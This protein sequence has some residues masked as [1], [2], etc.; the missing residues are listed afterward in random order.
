MFDSAMN[1]GQ[2]IQPVLPSDTVSKGGF[3]R[4]V[5]EAYLDYDPVK[6][7]TTKFLPT[8]FGIGVSAAGGAV[9]FANLAE[10]MDRF[11][12]TVRPGTGLSDR[13]IEVIESAIKENPLAC[14]AVAG[15]AVAIVGFYSLYSSLKPIT[16]ASIEAA[17]DGVRH[18]LQRAIQE[19]EVHQDQIAKYNKSLSELKALLPAEAAAYKQQSQEQYN[20]CMAI[21]RDEANFMAGKLKGFVDAIMSSRLNNPGDAPREYHERDFYRVGVELTSFVRNLDRDQGYLMLSQVRL[22]KAVKPVLS[23]KEYDE[24]NR[25]LWSFPERPCLYVEQGPLAREYAETLKYSASEKKQLGVLRARIN[26]VLIQ[27]PNLKPDAADNIPKP[28]FEEFL[29]N[30]PF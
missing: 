14:G 18:E 22:L 26:Q 4:Y 21:Y 25:I 19:T 20:K 9:A 7:T 10:R 23:D 11:P 27:Y 30:M 12:D 3:F 16:K 15:A 29:K 6:G 2:L 8:A 24:F 13:V 28:S 5:K 17:R 1:P